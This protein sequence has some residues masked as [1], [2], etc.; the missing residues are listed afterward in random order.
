MKFHNLIAGLCGVALASAHD[1]HSHSHDTEPEIP[2][3]ERE[4]VQ[5]SA[6]ELERKWGFEVCFF[7][8]FER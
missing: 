5:D 4:F 1:H 8:L 6:E 7:I 2:L 3:H